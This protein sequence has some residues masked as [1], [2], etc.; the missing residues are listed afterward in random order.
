MSKVE[1]Q[2]YLFDYRHDSSEWG[3]EIE[4]TSPEDAKKRLQ[5]LAWANYRGRV[6]ATI[7]LP[8]AAFWSLFR[9]IKER[10]C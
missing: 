4:A 2:R 9:T 3:I 6:A 5:A 8:S 10:L 1:F 7:P